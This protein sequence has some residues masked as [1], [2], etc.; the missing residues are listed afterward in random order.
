MCTKSVHSAKRSNWVYRARTPQI[1]D[2]ALP[3]TISGLVLPCRNKLYE[4]LPH[5][6]CMQS[7]RSSLADR[8]ANSRC[9]RTQ[10]PL[11]KEIPEKPVWK[12]RL[13]NGDL[14]YSRALNV[15]LCCK[16]DRAAE[17]CPSECLWIWDTTD[18]YGCY[19][20]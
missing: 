10:L 1:I 15:Q 7:N 17:V 16:Y 20:G 13:L 19:V 14:Q 8:H 9:P 3:R 2:S 12:R 6:L 4:L 5:P 18:F 11:N